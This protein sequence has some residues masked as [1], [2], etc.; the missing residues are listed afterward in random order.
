MNAGEINGIKGNIWSGN[1]FDAAKVLGPRF[2][3]AEVKKK[4]QV[5]VAVDN[6]NNTLGFANETLSL[7]EATYS[8]ITTP[9]GRPIQE[10][11]AKEVEE[12]KQEAALVAQLNNINAKLSNVLRR[13][14]DI[15]SRSAL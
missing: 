10:S 9:E 4:S 15:I 6:I 5:D 2:E 11:G 14:N 1:P 12:S 13:M 7:M 3:V 8:S